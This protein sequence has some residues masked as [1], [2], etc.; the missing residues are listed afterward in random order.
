[1]RALL[2]LAPALLVTLLASA[3]GNNATSSSTT[4]TGATTSSSTGGGGAP[5]IPDPVVNE[6]TAHQKPVTDM[7]FAQDIAT[8]FRTADALPDLDVRSLVFLDKDLYA[9]TAGG[10]AKLPLGDTKFAAMTVSGSGPILDMAVLSGQLVLARADSVE[11][12]TPGGASAVWPAAGKAITSVAVHGTSVL[13]GTGTG[14]FTIDMAGPA[15]VSAAQGFAVR[16]VVVVGD[17]AWLATAAGVKRVDLVMNKALADLA[18]PDA[19]PDDDVRA[20]AVTSDGKQVL[21]AASGGLSHLDAGTGKATLVV[22][23]KDALPNGD[24]RAVA[25]SGGLV[26][27]GHGLGATAM[28]ADHK[29]HYHTQRWLPDEEVTAVLAGA[30]GTRWVAT[31]KG[32]SKIELQTRS[33]ADKTALYEPTVEAYY[34]MDGIVGDSVS[35]ADPWDHSAGAMHHDFDNDGL[36]TEMQVAAWCLAYAETKDEAYYKNARRAMDAMLL[37]FDVPGET[38]AAQGKARGFITR[39]LVRDDEGALFE[40]KAKQSNWHLQKFGDH[41]YYWKDD[42]SSDEYAGHYFG[43]PL[44]YDLCAKTED[45]KKAIRDRI[46]LSTSY[47]V[48]NGEK[49]IDLD[50]QPTKFGRWDNLATAAD[51]DLGACLAAGKPNCAESYGGGG[52]LNSIEILGHL[53]A[54][55][56][57]TGDPKFYQEYERLAITERYGDMIPLTDH[58]F[59]V[60]SRTQQNHSDHELASLAYFTLLR[61]E[62]NADRRAKWQKSLLDFY[63]WEKLERNT[64]EIGVIA[65]AT[66]D[67]A[68]FGDAA[69]TLREWPLDLRE[70]PY[71]NGHRKDVELDPKK[72]RFNKDQFTTVLPYDEIRTM[73]WNGNPYAVSGGGSGNSVQ[74][75]W[76]YLLPYWM[77]RHFKALVSP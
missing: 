1:M 35:Y 49:L 75:P 14:L 3:C 43:I 44:F 9:G 61:Y 26:L 18:A 65:S 57:I 41:S 28:T 47:I 60:T 62:P 50:G 27:T 64:L 8:P 73:E 51:G 55:W 33:L 56:H 7:P 48:D 70:W 59:T 38:F 23:G 13:V 29:D 45:E 37:F 39:S 36:W 31:H 15:P 69:R 21:A 10:L 17:V 46:A 72:D 54:A 42:T 66:D 5:A 20:L 77:M 30:D 2:P 6:Q 53:L 34:R 11:A 16:D 68:D 12:W 74:G 52:W 22:P 4:G 24:L 25:E 76:P 19:L 71:D 63:G 58:T 67:G 32:L 40:E